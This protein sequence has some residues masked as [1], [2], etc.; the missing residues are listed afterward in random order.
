MKKLLFILLFAASI[1]GQS[2]WDSLGIA[3]NGDHD[4]GDPNDH[5]GFNRNRIVT[6]NG[7][8]WMLAPEHGGQEIVYKSN[9]SGKT[10]TDIWTDAPDEPNNCLISGP[11]STIFYWIRDGNNIYQAKFDYKATEISRSIIISQQE[12]GGEHSSYNMISGTADSNGVLY[13]LVH[14]N[15]L[16]GLRPDSIW[17]HRSI[18]TGTTWSAAGSSWL[19]KGTNPAVVQDTSFGYM[20]VDVTTHDVLVT[21]YSSWNGLTSRMATSTD[22]GETWVEH[23]FNDDENMHNIYDPTMLCYRGDSIFFA[24]QSGR[25]S[26]TDVHGLV[27][28]WTYDLGETFTPWFNIDSSNNAGYGDPAVA[29]TSEGHIVIAYRS[30]ARPDLIAITAGAQFRQRIAYSTDQGA[31]WTFPSD[32]F[33]HPNAETAQDSIDYRTWRVG[34]K[35]NIRY[36]TWHNYGGR[37]E[38]GWMQYRDE[39]GDTVNTYFGY[40]DDLTIFDAFNPIP[41]TAVT[42]ISPASANISGGD[43]VTIFGSNF[44]ETQGTGSVV[45]GDSTQTVST[46][47]N[48]AIGLFLK[49]YHEMDTVDVTVTNSDDSASTLSNSFWYYTE[50]VISSVTPDSAH[51]GR[52]DSITIVGTN[53]LSEAGSTG[54]VKI[55]DSTQVIDTWTSTVIGLNMK[56]Y[57]D[58]GNVDLIVCDS[59]GKCDTIPFRYYLPDTLSITSLTPDQ[60]DLPAGDTVT[61]AGVNFREQGTVNFGDSAQFIASWTNTEIKVRTTDYHEVGAVNVEICNADDSCDTEN[62][63][64]TFS[65]T[66]I[67]ATIVPDSGIDTGGDTISISGTYF[68]SVQGSGGVTFGDSTQT[69]VTWAPGLITVRSKGYHE[70]G[71]VDVVVTDDNDSSY[72]VSNGF[73]YH[74]PDSSLRMQNISPTSS[75]DTGGATITITGINFEATR[76]DGYVQ[77]GD[78]LAASYVSWSDIEVVVTTKAYHEFGLVDIEMCSSIDSCQTIT[79]GFRYTTTI[80]DTAQDDATAFKNPPFKHK[81]F[82]LK[83]F[84]R[85]VFK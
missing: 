85:N 26:S 10:W 8:T 40:N 28:C 11:D 27:G 6:I 7:V 24:A 39:V 16:D 72:T 21:A 4:T 41:V 78:S 70:P 58:S 51:I 31:T 17:C 59:S 13:I 22:S 81:P 44:L 84:L 32:N 1:F 53:F 77:F 55:G 25:D 76:G 2:G 82:R 37:L 67:V 38:W 48:T 46:W 18:D 12:I 61:I 65:S 69:V 74:I 42:S 54:H 50:P 62:N 56:T 29:M 30:G 15:T 68:L 23:L 36:Q 20:N 71:L 79:N 63:A 52:T 75:P 64:F 43:S 57:H 45:I 49:G 73:N 14:Y 9:D 80:P 47:S 35:N 66:P 33:Y 19:V 60:C 3:I 5:F 83:T 34:A